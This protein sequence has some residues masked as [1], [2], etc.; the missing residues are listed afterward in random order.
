MQQCRPEIL[1]EI[2][3]NLDPDHSMKQDALRASALLFKAITS[4]ARAQLFCSISIVSV[5]HG[6]YLLRV[7]VSARPE[8]EKRG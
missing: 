2:L 6:D 1:S 8:A 3:E 5:G 4:V 7:Q